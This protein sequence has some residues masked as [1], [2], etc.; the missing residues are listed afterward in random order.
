MKSILKQTSWIFGAQ[1]LGRIIGFFYTIF[2]ARS[3]GVEDF[4]LYSA[5][6][7]Y[8][9]LFAALAD[10]GFSRFLV[11]EIA[12]GTLNLAEVF[13]NITILRLTITS[14]LF[15]IFSL[16]LYF[17]DPDKFR[18]SLTL[19]AVLTVLPA[20]I[21]Q[22]ADSIFIAMQKMK[23]SAFSLV[24]LNI[25]TT[26]AGIFLLN[27]G[28]GVTGAVVALI[29]G[30]VVYFVILFIFLKR[31]KVPIISIV[32]LKILKQAL[33]GS[34]PYGL[35]AILGLIYFRIDTLMLSYMRGN[36][37]TGIYSAGYKFLEALIFIPNSLSIVLFPTLAKLHGH[38]LDKIKLLFFQSIKIMLLLSA[39]VFV[40]YNLIL[41]PFIR[42]FLPNYLPSIDVIRILSLTVP[43]MFIHVPVSQIL[44][45][46]DKYLKAVILISFLPLLFNII[47]NLIFI[48]RFG[49]L[50]ASWITVASD[51]LSTVILLFFIKKLV[52][53]NG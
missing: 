1:A 18:V 42:F 43:F 50:A 4:G 14:F 30:Q 37:E 17:L 52:F 38:D 28:F 6:L 39:F 8:Y 16:F 27:S 46:T 35:L 9:S 7:A 15:A 12:R 24:T 33:I 45:S 20:S 5:A 13:S 40:A 36:F 41:P 47:L 48:P 19:L 32:K 11:R 29:F 10:F 34:L 44:L 21:A 51:V 26:L 31:Q 53:K 25:A 3:L 23:L 2:L 49:F 22:T